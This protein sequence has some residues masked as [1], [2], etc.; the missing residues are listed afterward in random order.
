MSVE[1]EEFALWRISVN[2]KNVLKEVNKWECDHVE[3]NCL[4]KNGKNNKEIN[5]KE[6]RWQ[7]DKVRQSRQENAKHSKEMHKHRRRDAYYSESE[8]AR[9]KH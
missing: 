9:C 5:E 6:F 8:D 4:Q 7:Q 3:C 2:F 1:H